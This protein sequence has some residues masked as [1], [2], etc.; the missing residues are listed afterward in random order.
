MLEEIKEYLALSSNHYVRTFNVGK[1]GLVEFASNDQPHNY[2]MWLIGDKA[3]VF[4][5]TNLT[6]SLSDPSEE[7]I[8]S[9]TEITKSEYLD[10]AR[11]VLAAVAPK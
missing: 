11:L 9:K 1:R 7:Q 5:G 6:R 8:I 2:R 10:I 3:G 4:K